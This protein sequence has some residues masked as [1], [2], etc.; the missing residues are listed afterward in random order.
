[1]LKGLIFDLDGVITDT[2]KYHFIAWQNTIENKLK[3][4]IDKSHQDKI[5]GL[6]R[7]DTLDE[8][9]NIIKY[10]NKMNLEQKNHICDIKNKMY[11]NL[12]DSNITKEDILPGITQLLNDA[13][14]NNIKLA[15]AS[16]SKNAT[17]I[18]NSLNL[19]EAFDF[20]VNTNEIKNGKPSPEIYL[21]AAQGLNL[22]ASECMGF[23]DAPVGIA[24]LNS[25]KIFSVGIGSSNEITDRA[26]LFFKSTDQLKFKSLKEKFM[27][28]RNEI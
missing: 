24:G 5:R 14:A 12:I 26:K 4:K 8:I 21:N 23:E 11:I 9:L 28:D 7:I 2:A 19:Y 27:G 25:A 16:S 18:L 17:K 20:I 15:I 6:S 10:K 3:I 22:N 1:M 13:K